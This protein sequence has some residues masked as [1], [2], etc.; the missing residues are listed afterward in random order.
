VKAS[1]LAPVL[2]WVSGCAPPSLPPAEA[3]PPPPGAGEACETLGT[4]DLGLTRVEA[5]AWSGEL[6]LAGASDGQRGAVVSLA[7]RGGLVETGRLPTASRVRALLVGPTHAWVGLHA[8]GVARI[9]GGLAR[10]VSLPGAVVHALAESEH[11]VLAA[12][13]HGDVYALSP[14]GAVARRW[15][16]PQRTMALA[17]AVRGGEVYAANAFHGWLVPI[18]P[19]GPV[20][21]L[22][23]SVNDSDDVA[24]LAVDGAALWVPLPFHGIERIDLDDGSRALWR[25]DPGA[26]DLAPLADGRLAVA[27]G[28]AGVALVDRAELVAEPGLAPLESPAAWCAVDGPAYRVLARGD[29]V[30]VAHGGRVSWLRPVQAD[31]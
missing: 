31:K 4:I 10:P 6:I 8:G 2:A 23:G 12:T 26:W 18:E 13:E 29:E 16:M 30:I 5:L 3:P 7:L 15:P 22:A 28:D 24:R 25:H 9:E 27:T 21:A 20:Q 17:L 11:G 14:D 19:E 1:A